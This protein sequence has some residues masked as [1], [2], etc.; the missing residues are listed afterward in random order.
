MSEIIKESCPLLQAARDRARGLDDPDRKLR[1]FLGD[2]LCDL[3]TLKQRGRELALLLKAF[4]AKRQD[5]IE[6][7]NLI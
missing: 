1:N 5:F 7:I 3:V 6:S 4:E 2:D